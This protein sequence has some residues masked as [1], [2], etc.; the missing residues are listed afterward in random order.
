MQDVKARKRGILALTNQR[1]LFL[2][3]HGVFGKSYHQTLMIPLDRLGGVSIGGSLIP[4]VSIASEAQ[5][6]VFH[7][8]GIGKTEFPTFRQTIMN[9]CQMRREQIEAEKRKDRVQIIFDFTML[10]EY[11]EK[12]GLVLQ[13]TKCPECNAPLP[14]PTT[15]KQIVCQ[16]CGSTI[17]AQDIFEKIKALI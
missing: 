7:I 3:A 4:F 9:F 1:L 13:K 2:E 5:S 12:G 6:Y 17:L 14:I 10:K 16:H 15:G 8:D 11:M